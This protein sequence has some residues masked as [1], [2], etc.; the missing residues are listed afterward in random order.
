MLTVLPSSVGS[1]RCIR[2][3]P[4]F[5]SSM[6]RRPASAT[7]CDRYPESLACKSQPMYFRSALSIPPPR[8]E[9]DDV[10]LD[11]LEFPRPVCEPNSLPSL[12]IAEFRDPSSMINESFAS[13]YPSLCVLPLHT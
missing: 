5:G 8:A 13:V 6:D 11:K 3:V 10:E 12:I 4:T 1:V 7:V 9:F 2:I